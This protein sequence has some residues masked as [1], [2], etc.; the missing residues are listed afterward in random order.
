VS[1]ESLPVGEKALQL[2]SAEEVFCEE[3]RNEGL[4]KV[5]GTLPDRELAVIQT[6]YGLVDGEFKT[7]EECAVRFGVTRERLRQIEQMALSMLRHPKNQ[8]VLSGH[9]GEG[10]REYWRP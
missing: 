6:R 9:T 4:R 5:L 3:H 2:P 8:K 1:L 7:L 10:Y